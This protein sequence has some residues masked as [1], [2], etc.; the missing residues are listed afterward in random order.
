MHNEFI[1]ELPICLQFLISHSQK[2]NMQKFVL[3]SYYATWSN[4]DL[5]NMK[6]FKPP[7]QL[8]FEHTCFISPSRRVTPSS[9]KLPHAFHLTLLSVIHYKNDK[10]TP[11][12]KDIQ[13]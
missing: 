1:H 7:I 8:S 3:H 9:G 4:M 5:R 11:G 13:I 12:H 2:L 6:T 10:G